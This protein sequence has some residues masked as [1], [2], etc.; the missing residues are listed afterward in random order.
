MT[1][2]GRGIS[3][4]EIDRRRVP[5]TSMTEEERKARASAGHRAMAVNTIVKSAGLLSPE[6]RERLIEALRSA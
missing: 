2:T 6:Q 5:H 3:N 1:K 4:K